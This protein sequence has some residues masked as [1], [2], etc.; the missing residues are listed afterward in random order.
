MRFGDYTG[1]SIPA[2][3]VSVVGFAGVREIVG[4]EFELDLPEGST[5]AELSA[6][7]ERR[8][9]E[10]LP[11]RGRIA[12]AIDGQLGN[13]ESPLAEGVEV[14]LLPPVSG[15]SHENPVELVHGPISIDAV[16][17]RVAH[18]GAGAVVTFNG[19]VRNHHQGRR[20]THLTYDAYEVMALEVLHRIVTEIETERADV[21]VAISHRLG[22]VV[23]GDTSVVIAVSSPHRQAGYEASREVLE[24]LKREVPIWKRE[25]Y[26]DGESTWREEEPLGEDVSPSRPSG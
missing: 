1:A 11:Y 19:T 5:V 17:T 6:E 18:P 12:V 16:G 25:H 22:S 9:P 24:R 10:L 13:S 26:A 23:A 2:M 14:A 15:G 7:L 20:V 21:R 4:S 8:F 3:K